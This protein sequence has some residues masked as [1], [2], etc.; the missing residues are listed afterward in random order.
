MSRSHLQLLEPSS[1]PFPDEEEDEPREEYILTEDDARTIL[2]KVVERAILDVRLGPNV[3]S[4]ELKEAYKDARQW[5]FSDDP[6]FPSFL[7]ICGYIDLD[8]D[9]VREKIESE[10]EEEDG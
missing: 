4:A 8:P 1:S 9:A 6:E 3:R 5:L 7:G 10:E 2:C